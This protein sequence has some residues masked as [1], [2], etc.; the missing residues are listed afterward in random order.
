ML[1]TQLKLSGYCPDNRPAHTSL[2]S[3]SR[4]I[5]ASEEVM[6]AYTKEHGTRLLVPRRYLYGSQTTEEYDNS[7]RKRV[8][9]ALRTNGIDYL[10]QNP[11]VVCS[12]LDL[13]NG[14]TKLVIYNGHHRVRFSGKFGINNIPSIGLTPEELTEMINIYR[15]E[16]NQPD[17]DEQ[18][19]T[20]RLLFYSAE[21][22]NSFDSLSNNKRPLSLSAQYDIRRIST[23]FECN[24][25]R[26][27]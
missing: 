14:V 27:A 3:P 18:T 4:D 10:L 6:K 1:E 20:D 15:I 24:R 16:Q 26:A 25:I 19:V 8:E 12:L 13:S 21:A 7:K 9:G 11:V 2:Y 17:I 5:Y 23:E 22:L